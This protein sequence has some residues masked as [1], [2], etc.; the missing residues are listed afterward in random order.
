MRTARCLVLVSMLVSLPAQEKPAT[1]GKIDAPSAADERPVSGQ[2]TKPA[3]APKSIAGAETGKRTGAASGHTAFEA[4]CDPATLA[5]G[6]SG[7]LVVLMKLRG[8]AVMLDPPPVEFSFS[9]H[10]GALSIDGEPRFRPATPKGL[11]PAMKGT[12]VHDDVAI[13]DVPVTASPGAA[14]GTHRLEL[15]IQYELWNGAKGGG[16]GRFK[17]LV[18]GEV[19]VAAAPRNGAQRVEREGAAATPPT[20]PGDGAALATRG[21]EAIV[22]DVASPQAGEGAAAA[23]PPTAADGGPPYLLY[24]LGAAALALAA[25]LAVRIKSSRA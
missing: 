23:V 18:A 15:A 25:L 20:S 6:E 21:R 7:T 22:Q 10:Q 2:A 11:A 1:Q 13:F 4:A 5:P 17:D 12:P 3:I 8:D 16:Y 19:R 9:R 14:E 24:A